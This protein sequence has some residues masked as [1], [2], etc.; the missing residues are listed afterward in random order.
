MGH[1]QQSQPG[2]EPLLKSVSIANVKAC[3]AKT[4]AVIAAQFI[5]RGDEEEKAL[6]ALRKAN[7][8]YL[9]ASAYTK[10]FAALPLNQKEIEAFP[11]E[12]LRARGGRED[13]AIGDSGANSPALW[14]FR[15]TAKT[16]LDRDIT[17]KK[18]LEIIEREFHQRPEKIAPSILEHLHTLLRH[19]RSRA[20]GERRKESVKKNRT[21]RGR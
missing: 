19:F 15:A 17:Y 5:E 11:E 14:H 7:A 18:F 9:M 21:K 2:I 1:I 6:E 4:L 8:L 20:R 3:D 12:A 13:L 10:E 16:K